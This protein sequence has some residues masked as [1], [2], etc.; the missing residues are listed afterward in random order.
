MIKYS[1]I[2]MPPEHTINDITAFIG[3]K[4]RTSQPDPSRLKIIKKSVDARHKDDIHFVYTVAFASENENAVLKKNSGNKNISSYKEIPYSLPQRAR[5]SKHPVVVGFG[6]AGMFAALYLAQCGVRPIVLERGLDVDSRK[7]KV[8]M[9]W[10]KGILDTEC[11][12]QFGEGGA[13]TFSDGKL[14][15]GVNNPLSKTVF[16][17]FVRHGAPEEI[18][19]EAKPHIGTDKLSETVKNIRNDIISLGGEVIFGAKFCGYD[20]E[21]GRIKAISYIKNDTEITIETDNVILAIGHSARDVFYMLKNRNVTMQTKN[22]AV[23]VRIENN[24]TD[25]DRSLD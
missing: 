20:T 6:P 16:E 13:G 17:E 2:K 4:L 25:L 14:N 3:K 22:L 9:F 12:V 7:E 19:Y 24:Q 21:N 10:E 8:S 1:N 11:N 18:M 23:G 5:L 15:T